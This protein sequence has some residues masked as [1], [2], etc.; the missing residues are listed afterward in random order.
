MRMSISLL[1][2]LISGAVARAEP[3]PAEAALDL[4]LFLETQAQAQHRVLDF[5][6]VTQAR[7]NE[8]HKH[9]RYEARIEFPTGLSPSARRALKNS[10]VKWI[11]GALEELSS[12]PVLIELSREARFR[13]I[14]SRWSTLIGNTYVLLD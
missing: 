11:T 6:I 3:G 1:A 13:K 7:L 12:K 10:D 9:V 5:R 8:F 14:Y 2:L 4:K